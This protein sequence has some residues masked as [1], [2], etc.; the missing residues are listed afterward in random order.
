[1]QITPLQ[2]ARMVAA[3]ANG[4]TLFRPLLVS[5][6]QSSGTNSVYTAQPAPSSTLGYSPVVFDTIR[7]AMCNVTLDSK[8]TARFV[9]E[10][11]YRFQGNNGYNIVVCGKTGTAQTGDENTPPQAWFAAFAP[12]NDPE[13]AIVVIV[14]NSCEGSEVAAPIVRRIVEDYYGMSH[15]EW[16]PLWQ[17]GCSIL[18]E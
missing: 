10:E 7:Q 8:G 16:P 1:M 11:W 5:R 17:T 15:S 4:G 14:E 18:G 12:Q 6:V 13:I 2:V 9:F 3:I